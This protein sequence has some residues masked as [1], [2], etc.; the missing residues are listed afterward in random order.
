LAAGVAWL[1][2]HLL[3][4]VFPTPR[5]FQIN[6]GVAAVVF[7]LTNGGFPSGHA[8]AAFA[9]ALTVWRHHKKVG[10]VYLISAC[11][12]GLARVLANVHY[13]IDIVGGAI[14]GIIVAFVVEKLHFRKLFHKS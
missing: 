4:A 9:L 3:K 7:P 10:I 13:P 12:I 11:L 14:L 5:P 2:A 8:A 1:L 6:G